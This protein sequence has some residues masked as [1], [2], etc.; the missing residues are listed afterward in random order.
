MFKSGFF[1]RDDL[2]NGEEME[3]R[4]CGDLLA[5]FHLFPVPEIIA[6]KKSAMTELLTTLAWYIFVGPQDLSSFFT[7]Q[8]APSISTPQ[9]EIVIDRTTERR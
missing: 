7:T 8:L 2:G 1:R 5:V 3:A 6:P 4:R 9:N